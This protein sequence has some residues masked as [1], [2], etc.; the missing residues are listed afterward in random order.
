MTTKR[1]TTALA[2]SL[3]LALAACGGVEPTAS[4]AGELVSVLPTAPRALLELDLPGCAALPPGE[5]QQVQLQRFPAGADLYVAYSAADARPL[6]VD[7]V[8]GF[9]RMGVVVVGPMIPIDGEVPPPGDDPVPIDG[10]EPRGD[11]PRDDPVPITPPGS[12]EQ[13]NGRE[14]DPVPINGPGGGDEQHEIAA[15]QALLLG[16]H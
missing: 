10:E 3:A 4:T 2:L 8:D 9:A 7:D 13:S 5:L 1:H 15:G 12:G 16:V 11:Q 6:C 14:D